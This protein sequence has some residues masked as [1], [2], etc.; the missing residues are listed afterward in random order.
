MAS[1]GKSRGAD[2]IDF[3][4]IS[5]ENS[6]NVRRDISKSDVTVVGVTGHRILADV[7]LIEAGIDRALARIER[8]AELR[9][10]HQRLVVLSPLA[11]G[12]DR[13]VVLRAL[14]RPTFALHAVLPFP[15]D[16]YMQDFSEP[17]SRAE[18]LR[19]LRRAEEVLELSGSPT[20]DEGYEAAAGCI[21]EKSDMLIAVWDGKRA[22]GRGGTAEFVELARRRD[23]PLAWIQ[24]GNRS[25]GT[26]APTSLG[27]VQGQVVFERFQSPD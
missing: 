7:L 27:A 26:L 1:A 13:L 21:V 15:R 16:D 9:D 24:A 14:A 6:R 17:D 5:V 20:R 19:L 8:E 23:L 12:A 3:A 18:F 4:C 11:E 25:P 10:E 22:Q 2:E